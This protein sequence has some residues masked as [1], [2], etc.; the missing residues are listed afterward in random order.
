VKRSASGLKAT[1][2]LEAHFV[3]ILA[4]AAAE[5]QRRE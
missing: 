2:R 4:R 3:E 1:P 5:I